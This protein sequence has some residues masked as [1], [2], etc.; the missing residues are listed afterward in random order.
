MLT[1]PYERLRRLFNRETALHELEEE[2]RLHRELRAE[3]FRAG[4]MD[5]LEA[6]SAARHRFGNAAEFADRSRDAWGWQ[7]T[8][9]LL[10]DIRYAMRRLRLRPGFSFGVVGIL[11]LG[12]GAT[13][14][15]FSAIDAALLRPLPF[16][17][18]AALVTLEHVNIPTT[19]VFDPSRPRPRRFDVDHVREMREIVTSMGVYASGGLNL[20][21]A[22]QPRRVSVGVVSADFF[23]TLGV[24]PALGRAID[25]SD[26]AAGANDVVVLSWSLW[27]AAFGGA[28]VRGTTIP[29]NTK[30]YEVIGVMPRGFSFPNESDLWIP[31]AI[32]TTGATFEPFR[33]YLP[34]VII[35]RLAAG[36]DVGIADV[37]MRE[38]FERATATAMASEPRVPGRRSS[39]EERLDEMRASGIVRPLR[40]ELVG[41]RRKALLVLFGITGILL[42]IVCANVTSLLI[43]HGFARARELAVRTALGASRGRI[44]R[45]LLA[46]SLILSS[47]GTAI[48]VGS[49]PVLL[50]AI[51]ALMP[52]S[53]AGVAPAQIDLRVLGF[54]STIAVLTALVFGLWPAFRVTRASAAAV[55]Q[56]GGG[57]GATSGGARR[58][59][60][61]LV[62]AELGF[63]SV[64]LIGAGL[65]L[66][67]FERLLATDPGFAAERVATFE[68]SFVRGVPQPERM[69]RLD[70]IL[71]DLRSEPGVVAAGSVNDLPLRGGAGGIGISVTVAGAPPEAERVFPRYLIASEGYFETLGIP[72]RHGRTFTAR[73]GADAAQVAVI[74]ES[75]AR[76][77]WPEVSPLGRTFL[78]G[79]DG[80]PFEVIGVVADVRERGVE[81]TAGPQM[82][83]PMRSQIGTN[84]AVLA[85]GT[86][87]E[88]EL[89]GALVRAVR[90]VDPAQAIYN[91]RM[92]E[93]V[94]GTST[95]SRRANT[96]LIGVFGALGLLIAAVGVYAV[97]S[98]LVA[99]RGREFG[100]RAALGAGPRDVMVLVGREVAVM[101]LVGIAIGTGA[102]WAA[103]RVMAGLVYGVDVRDGF[104][105]LAAPAVLLVAALVAAAGPVRRAMR[106]EAASVMREE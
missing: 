20:A 102:A 66:R 59:Q 19:L 48:G 5:P 65:M 2:M 105:F 79:G 92:M 81:T 90:R 60:R 38:G 32:P 91:V 11:A 17:E 77:Y 83:M 76:T 7:F 1:G 31:M 28:E 58:L 25:A 15:M 96:L 21:D 35:A 101:S 56:G 47:L 49:A 22:E 3:Q 6:D 80:P 55:I 36:V 57:H 54:A 87:S 78:F 18:P 53:L 64:L 9:S 103:A 10:T 33:G 29:L 40:A 95:R 62:A 93:E 24:A 84:V 75:M 68:M 39:M 70:A 86:A 72:L 13:T 37:R 61:V 12:I 98:N 73:D 26:V 82:Y 71:S 89:L 45:Q 30:R 8:E 100:I 51:S 46:E 43:A 69:S 41:D 27:Q 16:A 74:S 85:R 42:L 67:S 44:V 50:S 106:V 34:T 23:A 88:A 4:G 97:L 63:A 14:A 99:Q 104:T 94:I 52:A